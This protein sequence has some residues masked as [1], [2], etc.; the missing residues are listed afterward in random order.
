MVMIIACHEWSNS[1][2]CRFGDGC[3]FRH[4]VGASGQYTVIGRS[5]G[6]GGGCGGGDETS[7]EYTKQQ[8]GQTNQQ[9][10]KR[11]QH[12]S[13][14]SEVVEAEETETAVAG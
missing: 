7:F 4:E 9:N 8:S 10:N 13:E 14:F 3:K 1:G 11:R 5:G 12:V 2:R 6:G